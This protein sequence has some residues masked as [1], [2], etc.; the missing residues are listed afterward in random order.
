MP[1]STDIYSRSTNLPVGQ[2]SLISKWWFV[3]V[4]LHTKLAKQFIRIHAH[5]LGRKKEKVLKK[6]STWPFLMNNNCSTK[7]E[8]RIAFHSMKWAKSFASSSLDFY[9]KKYMILERK[10]MVLWY[11]IE[12]TTCWRNRNENWPILVMMREKCR[13]IKQLAW[14]MRQLMG[15]A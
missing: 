11:L 3:F 9:K 13:K 2:W 15:S 4:F 6:S 5:T 10:A 14:W 7:I 1:H 12:M 8:L